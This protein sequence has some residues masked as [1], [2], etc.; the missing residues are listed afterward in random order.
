LPAAFTVHEA[1]GL[2]LEICAPRTSIPHWCPVKA[3]RVSTHRV[4]NGPETC[5]ES[6]V[7]AT[8][9]EAQRTALLAKKTKMVWGCLL[10][11]SLNCPLSELS[12]SK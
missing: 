9:G 10:E 4:Q 6:K 7:P 12:M 2:S 1:G 11:C 3:C 8:N 5:P